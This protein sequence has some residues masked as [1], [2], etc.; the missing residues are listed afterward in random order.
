MYK[1]KLLGITYDI[2]NC[3]EIDVSVIHEH[4]PK[5]DPVKGVELALSEGPESIIAGAFATFLD[6]DDEDLKNS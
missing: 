4:W 5:V 6:Y 1:E 2:S 3:E